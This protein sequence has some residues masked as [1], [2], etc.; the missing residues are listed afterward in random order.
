R[1]LTKSRAR[2]WTALGVFAFSPIPSAQLFVA[3]GLMKVR[4]LP[5]TL[6][7][8]AGRLCSYAIYAML[9]KEVDKRTDGG[10]IAAMTSPLWI[11]IELVGLAALVAFL[12]IDWGRVAARWRAWRR[13]RRRRG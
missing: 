5:L 9:A 2:K 12:R 7:F 3:A 1:A 6:G 4:L 10:V 11:G 8:F 13:K